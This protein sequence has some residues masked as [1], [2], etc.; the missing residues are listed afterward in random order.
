MKA[1][2]EKHKHFMKNKPLD[3]RVF[4]IVLAVGVITTILSIINTVLEGLGAGAI[5]S[6][7]ACLIVIIALTVVAFIF[8]KEAI[9][10]ILLCI[11]LNFIL[12]PVAFFFC[13]GIKSGMITYF[14]S[15]L[16][17]TVPT[18]S[19]KRTRLIIYLLSLVM[20]SATVVASYVFFPEWVT[21]MSDDAFYFDMLASFILNAFCIYLVASLT[22]KAYDEKNE[23]NEELVKKLESMTI[24][25][26]LTGVYNR[27]ELFRVLEEKVMRAEQNDLYCLFIF[28]IDEF[29]Q[30]NDTYGHVFGDKVLCEVANCLND[31]VGDIE[32][33]EIAAR[34]GGQE[35]VA[36]FHDDDFEVSYARAEKI[37]QKI[38]K[39]R[40]FENPEF[41]VT[42]SGGVDRCNG[43]RPR[44]ALH[45]VDDLLY[46]A[47]TTGKNQIT[48]KF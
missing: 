24:H 34:Y 21:P 22:V 30:A 14:I 41:R 39:L 47:K 17:L 36:V 18:I 28:D 26:E 10:H 6:T 35:F 19:K 42:I 9:C 8:D 48:R 12:L 15:G 46:L 5:L 4:M 43:M 27:R 11:L 44:Y 3:S 29:K 45:Q 23:E 32:D 13:G 2:Y 40:F 7:L 37:R 38:E 33:G 1:I 20:L 16:Y 25:D 31:E